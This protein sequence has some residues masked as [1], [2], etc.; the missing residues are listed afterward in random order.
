MARETKIGFALIVVLLTAFGLV[1]Y[2]KQ[3]KQ[4]ELIAQLNDHHTENTDDI[5]LGNPANL[6]SN[7][8]DAGNPV[9]ITPG[10]DLIG[11]PFE[12]E[13]EIVQN[14]KVINEPKTLPALFQE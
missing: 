5:E 6:T 10:S 8:E 12:E 3:A 4:Q 7:I 9:D 14:T 11:D 1:V 13:R 2:Q